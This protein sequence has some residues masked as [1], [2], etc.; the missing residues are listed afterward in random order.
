MTQETQQSFDVQD[1]LNE[2][3][4][5]VINFTYPHLV[6]QTSTDPTHHWQSSILYNAKIEIN[7]SLLLEAKNQL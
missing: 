2:L 4:Q 1:K 5:I 6:F 7:K 3:E